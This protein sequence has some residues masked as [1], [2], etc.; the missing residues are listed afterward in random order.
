[1]VGFI[2]ASDRELEDDPYYRVPEIDYITHF[3]RSVAAQILNNE[4]LKNDPLK[5]LG[6][7]SLYLHEALKNE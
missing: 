7:I 1:M 4:K 6:L 2:C 3:S 5:I